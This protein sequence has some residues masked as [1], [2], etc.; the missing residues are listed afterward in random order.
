[1]L[2]SLKATGLGEEGDLEVFHCIGME[3]GMWCC[4]G[5]VGVVREAG[6][7]LCGTCL[8]ERSLIKGKLGVNA[9][10]CWRRGGP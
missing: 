7:M 4:G 10:A 6:S 2:G 1:V 9:E 8:C 5:I 3:A